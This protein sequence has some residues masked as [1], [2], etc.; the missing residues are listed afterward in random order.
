MH[1]NTLSMALQKA[2]SQA[3]YGGGAPVS[4]TQQPAASSSRT[5]N[6]NIGGRTSAVNVA[7]QADS[8]NLVGLLRQLETAAQRSVSWRRGMAALFPLGSATVRGDFFG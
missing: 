1:T 4:G 8:D 6:I 5:V 3:L 7:S 2:A